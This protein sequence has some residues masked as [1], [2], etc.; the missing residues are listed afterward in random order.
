MDIK[1]H[2]K[3]LGFS[4]KDKV[5]GFEGVVSTVSFDLYGCIQVVLTPPVKD[6]RMMEGSWFDIT[7]LQ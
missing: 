5:T 2:L 7:R 6:G 1:E 4:A 3:V